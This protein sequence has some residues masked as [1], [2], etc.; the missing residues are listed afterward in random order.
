MKAVTISIVVA[1]FILPACGKS[2]KK[3]G[4]NNTTGN[5]QVE[6]PT[7]IVSKQTFEYEIEPSQS[8][9]YKVSLSNVDNY[10]VTL[11]AI[12]EG[13]YV[14]NGELFNADCKTSL[15]TGKMSVSGGIGNATGGTATVIASGEVCIKISGDNISKIKFSITIQ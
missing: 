2:K 15:G 4:S 14:L 3:K 13:Q 5:E 9:E 6:M 12:S 10:L 11:K 7:P 8:N 1:L